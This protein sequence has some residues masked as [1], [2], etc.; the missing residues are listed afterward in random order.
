MCVVSQKHDSSLPEE[1]C[2]SLVGKKPK[3]KGISVLNNRN[4]NI[5]F[6]FCF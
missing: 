5:C 1:S 4:Y 2:I 6:L 3:Q